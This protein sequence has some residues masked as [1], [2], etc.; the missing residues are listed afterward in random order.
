ME[1]DLIGV[2]GTPLADVPRRATLDPTTIGPGRSD[3]GSRCED[4]GLVGRAK[5]V[6]N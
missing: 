3:G 4:V 2:I 6:R 1:F 5:D